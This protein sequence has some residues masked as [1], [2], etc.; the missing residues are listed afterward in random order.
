MI[1]QLIYYTLFAFIYLTSGLE[2]ATLF[3]F[4]LACVNYVAKTNEE[5]FKQSLENRMLR[6]SLK[7][8]ERFEK[9][10]KEKGGNDEK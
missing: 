5:I 6:K 4:G 3:L 10:L 9:F 1:E 8:L 2:H 7:H